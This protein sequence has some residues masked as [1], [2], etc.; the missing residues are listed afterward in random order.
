MILLHWN[1]ISLYILL[2]FLLILFTIYVLLCKKQQTSNPMLFQ[3][4][5]RKL[6]KTSEAL[7]LNR[8][9]RKLTDLMFEHYLRTIENANSIGIFD[10]H[11]FFHTYGNPLFVCKYIVY[12]QRNTT[13]DDF[14]AA[15]EKNKLIKKNSEKVHRKRGNILGNWYSLPKNCKVCFLWEKREIS[16]KFLRIAE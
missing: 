9:R 11:W 14:P 13:V 7:Y 8:F 10:R 5:L 6:M 3:S 15:F 16:N 4:Y 2:I 12:L 1:R